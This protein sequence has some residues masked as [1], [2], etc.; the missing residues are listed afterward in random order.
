MEVVGHA[1]NPLSS[2]GSRL[3]LVGFVVVRFISFLSLDFKF[4][5]TIRGEQKFQ[6]PRPRPRPGMDPPG[7]DPDPVQLGPGL[8]PKKWTQLHLVPILGSI[9]LDPIPG[10]YPV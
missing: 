3:P 2:C 10:G 7:S 6:V 1:R 8:G 4:L 9:F 5:V